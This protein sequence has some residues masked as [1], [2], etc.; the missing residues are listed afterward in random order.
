MLHSPQISSEASSLAAIR[1]IVEQ[2]RDRTKHAAIEAL[3][4]QIRKMKEAGRNELVQDLFRAGI[5]AGLMNTL[6]IF[7]EQHHAELLTY[8]FA[9]IQRDSETVKYAFAEPMAVH[10]VMEYLRSEEADDYHRLMHQWLIN[11]QDDNAPAMFGK[12]MECR[13]IACFQQTTFDCGLLGLLNQS[14]R[15]DA[16]LLLLVR[17]HELALPRS[18][19]FYDRSTPAT[20][21]GWMERY[22]NSYASASNPAPLFMFPASDA[23]PDLIKTGRHTQFKDG[24]KTL[25]DSEWPDRNSRDKELQH[26]KGTPFLLILISTGSKVKQSKVEEWVKTK[27]NSTSQNSFFCV[28]DEKVAGEVWGQDFVAL[29]KTIKGSKPGNRDIGAVEK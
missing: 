28:L 12:S 23:G 14:T 5:R 15:R 27:A 21:W 9:L 8:G 18:P 7:L 17:V 3:K 26:W 19:T 4:K 13:S 29:A 1:S 22:R 24:M 11:T 6:T 10:A 25:L 16:L 2:A 20:S